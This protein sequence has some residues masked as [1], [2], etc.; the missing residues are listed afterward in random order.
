MQ[1][2]SDYTT[3]QIAQ[4]EKMRLTIAELNQG[5]ANGKQVMP[6]PYSRAEIGALS[7]YQQ[8]VLAERALKN[9][10]D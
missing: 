4:F 3:E 2:L 1:K 8:L 10:A 7:R 6:L 9:H 5:V